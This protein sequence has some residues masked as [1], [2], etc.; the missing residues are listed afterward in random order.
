MLVSVSN[1]LSIF[2]IVAVGYIANKCHV[3]P[4]EASKYL[5]DLLMCIASPCMILD[6]I[7]STTLREDMGT[8]T[9]EMLACA[10]A[11]F[12]CTFVLSRFLC[13]HVLHV[14]KEDAGVYMF[15]L[16]TINNGFMGF[17][18]TL[19]LFGED[20]LYLMVLFQ[21]ILVIYLYSAGFVQVDYGHTARVDL[22]ST[23]H[24]LVNPNTIAAALSMLMLFSGLHLP[25][26]LQSA[27]S[28]IGN[29][30]T[31]LSMLLIGVQLGSSNLLGILKNRKLV[32]LSVL[33]M[34]LLPLLT[35][36]AVNW[37]PL[38]AT[39][40]VAL[41]FGAAFPTAAASVPVTSMA[42]RNATLA[43][44]IVAFTTLLSM[45]TLP[46]TALLLHAV[47]SL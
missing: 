31:P 18:I 32:L 13:L 26:F 11:F 9:A 34:L 44:E 27:V 33:K 30:T 10:V 28:L 22:R 25:G 3:I 19:A 38:P 1:I 2:L 4:D 47:Y 40:K 7:S 6:S 17:P 39:L 36:L 21:I 23:L 46:V 37:L 5:V 35:F 15:C 8:L 20:I 24:Y 14:P 12:A 29:A 16:S 45:V 41:I 42:G 43:A